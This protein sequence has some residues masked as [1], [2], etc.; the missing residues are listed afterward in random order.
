[1]HQVLRWRVVFLLSV[2]GLAVGWIG[3][4]TCPNRTE[5]G[6]MGATVYWYRTLGFDVFNVNA[7]LTRIVVALPGAHV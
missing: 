6:H 7:P 2:Q 3:W 4:A 5:V 1:M